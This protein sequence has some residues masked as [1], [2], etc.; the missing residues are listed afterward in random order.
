MPRSLRLCR[1]L[2][3][4]PLVAALAHPVA[5]DAQAE[6]F[7]GQIMCGVW[8]FPP[9]NWMPLDGQLLPISQYQALFSLIG[10]TYGGDGRSSFALPDLRG[11]L[12]MHR[13]Q[14]PGLTDR[15]LGTA[16]GSEQMTLKTS[17]LPAHSHQVAPLASSDDATAVSPAGKVPATKARTTLYAEPGHLVSQMATT[18][19]A[20]GANEPV[21]KLQPY[22]TFNCVIAV[23]GIYP[24]RN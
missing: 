4:L 22:L 23:A 12:P 13:G 14:G 15:L 19:S 3:L 10:T 11:R 5:A 2:A 20:V 8:N 7:I 6:P 1:A 24:T 17:Q 18:T 9:R 16:G 21:D